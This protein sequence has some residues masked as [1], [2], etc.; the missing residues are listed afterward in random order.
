MLA[1][2][3][4]HMTNYSG[5]STTAFMY[6]SLE[7]YLTGGPEESLN[8]LYTTLVN[9]ILNNLLCSKFKATHTQPLSQHS[10]ER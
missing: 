8:I 5:S 7:I 10:S 6:L 4:M 3:Q 1:A 9:F 2:W